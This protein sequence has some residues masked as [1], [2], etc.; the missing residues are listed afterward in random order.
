[1]ETT[2]KAVTFG[3]PGGLEHGA[4]LR[5]TFAAEGVPQS[6]VAP[7]YLAWWRARPGVALYGRLAVPLV[8]T[9]SVTWGLEAGAG[10]VWFA[11]AGLG[12]SFEVVGDV[13]YGAATQEVRAAAYPVVSGQLGVVIAYEVLR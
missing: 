2:R 1:M 12:L 8:V 7:S 5:I 3:A 9:P 13:F 6:V 11:R 10:T 4:A